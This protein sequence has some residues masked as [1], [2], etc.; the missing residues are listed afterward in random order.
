MQVIEATGIT[1]VY[2]R[3]SEE[4]HAL[5][6]V[7]LSITP[8]EFVAIV[9]PSGAGKTA[10][11]NIIGCLDAPTSGTFVL[12]G[13]TVTGKMERDL[14]HIRRNTVGFVFQQFFLIP[15]L[16]ARENIALPLVFHRKKTDDP[17][18]DE[19]LDQVGL[20]NRASHY[21]HELSGGEMQRV[22]IGRALICR[23]KIL[24]ADE[25]TGNL[26]TKNSERLFSLLQELNRKGL[27]ILMVTHNPAL[28]RRAG[29]VIPLR[30]G[31]VEDDLTEN[32]CYPVLSKP[33][34]NH[35]TK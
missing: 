1:K 33:R 23:P 25:P 4:V 3:G 6:G 30:D 31:L 15:T 16:T 35:E 9:G 22:A 20:S 5:K 8:S 12:D 32:L 24:L 10:L 17:Y 7:S 2:R 13:I 26:D 28:A 21:P 19:I 29:R 18:I 14:V 27:T 11:M 34:F